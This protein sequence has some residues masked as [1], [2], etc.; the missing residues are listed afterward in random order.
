MI[1][2]FCTAS[3]WHEISAP[4]SH[5]W[6]LLHHVGNVIEVVMEVVEVGGC[7]GVLERLP[8]GVASCAHL[9]DGNKGIARGDQRI[10]H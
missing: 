10:Y 2:L 5:E 6:R 1:C 9:I 4:M 8:R 7:R 3:F